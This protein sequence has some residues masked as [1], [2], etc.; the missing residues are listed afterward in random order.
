MKPGQSRHRSPTA[1]GAVVRRGLLGLMASSLIRWVAMVALVA[2]VLPQVAA[3]LMVMGGFQGD[4]ELRC[5]FGAGSVEITMHHQVAAGLVCKPAVDHRHTWLETLVVGRCKSN[6]EPDHHFVF[7][8]QSVLVE[9]NY[10][11][12]QEIADLVAFE[13]SA[14]DVVIL[15]PDLVESSGPSRPLEGVGGLSPPLM[16]RRGVMMRI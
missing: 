1:S 15:E 4:H 14:F 10:S 7:G 12:V 13:S 9:E 5:N 6:D 2:A 8:R 3:G 11:R 16:M